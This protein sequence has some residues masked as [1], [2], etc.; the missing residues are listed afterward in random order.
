[1]NSSTKQAILEGLVFHRKKLE[2][3]SGVP[4]SVTQ[5]A[6]TLAKMTYFLAECVQEITK[7]IK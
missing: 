2:E 1:M 3:I 4:T 6:D 5:L 7:D